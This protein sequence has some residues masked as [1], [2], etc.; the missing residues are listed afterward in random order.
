[1]INRASGTAW[2][3]LRGVALTVVVGSI[4]TMASATPSTTYWAPSVATCQAKGVPQITYDTYS[5]KDSAYPI[6]TGLTI[7][8]LP[9][10]K[11]QAEIGYDVLLPGANPTQFYVNGKICIPEKAMGKGS[12]AIGVGIYN[13]GFK[14]DVTNYD[15]VYVMVQKSLP[16]GGYIA[17]GFYHGTPTAL[18]TSSEGKEAKNGALVGWASPD[19]KIGLTGLQKILFIGDIQTGKNVLGGGGFGADIYFNDYIGLIVGPVFYTDSKLQP[20]QAKHLWTAQIDIDIPL[21][22]AK[23]P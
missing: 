15:A 12:P 20:G 11:V 22:K 18:F 21:G 17:G 5:G 7:G 23:T 9:G 19:I 6:D 14:K 8:I 16:F 3:A 10:D 1:M 13:V 2:R 4:P